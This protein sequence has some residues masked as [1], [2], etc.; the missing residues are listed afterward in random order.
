MS[1]I[2]RNSTL[3][4]VLDE[5]DWEV[6]THE[7]FTAIQPIS[8]HRLTATPAGFLAGYGDRASAIGNPQK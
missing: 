3:R 6:R 2:E 5:D 8:Q 4:N 1:D 7:G